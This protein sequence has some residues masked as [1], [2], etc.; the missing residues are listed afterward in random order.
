MSDEAVKKR[1]ARAKQRAHVDLISLGYEVIPS[2]NRP[3][4]L[5]AYR[6]NEVRLIRICLDQASSGDEKRLKQYSASS[7]IS[8]ELWIRKSGE[9]RF[10]ITR[11]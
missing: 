1:M 11:I 9:E 6:G 3:V 4:C 7:V 8:R 10:A 5:V 2:D